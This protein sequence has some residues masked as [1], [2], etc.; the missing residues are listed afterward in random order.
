ME[1]Y[2]DDVQM[3]VKEALKPAASIDWEF[4]EKHI[5]TPGV[6]SSLKKQFDALTYTIPI[7]EVDESLHDKLLA[8]A[9]VVQTEATTEEKERTD[10]LNVVLANRVTTETTLEDIFRL[11]PHIR[12]EIDK[13]HAEQDYGKDVIY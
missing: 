3:A 4:F 5:E 2:F 12:D 1:Y 6:V 10:W 7:P 9:K 11:Y 8:E 13:E